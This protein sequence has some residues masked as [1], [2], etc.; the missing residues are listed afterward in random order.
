MKDCTL[1][2]SGAAA[3]LLAA[4]W[5]GTSVS[6]VMARQICLSHDS[7]AGPL[8]VDQGGRGAPRLP[9]YKE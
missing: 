5:C 6:A 7:G 3:A 9:L 1:I 8:P 2:T 4:A